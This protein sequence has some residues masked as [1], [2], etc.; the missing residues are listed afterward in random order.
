MDYRLKSLYEQILRGEPVK[1]TPKE[2]PKSL[3]EAYKTIL[4][5]R[6]AFY[7]KDISAGEEIPD[8]QGLET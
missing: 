5:E 2:Q 4:T 3:T 1:Q 6:T 7:A 8:I